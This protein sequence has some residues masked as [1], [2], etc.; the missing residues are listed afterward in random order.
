MLWANLGLAAF[1]L[2]PAFPLDGGRVLR[3]YVAG[4]M[5]YGR[6]T[7]FSA[8]AGRAMAYLFALCGL[9]LLPSLLL[10]AFFVYPGAAEEL[11]AV[12]TELRFPGVS[13]ALEMMTRFTTLSPADSLSLAIE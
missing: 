13:A 3:A 7:R 4:K 1:N 8:E 2:L 11:A 9:L 10:I 6:A 12:G 5:E